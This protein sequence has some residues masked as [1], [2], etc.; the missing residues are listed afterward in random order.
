MGVLTSCSDCCG[1]FEVSASSSSRRVKCS[2]AEK[3]VKFQNIERICQRLTK[4]ELD[5][6]EEEDEEEK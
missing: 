3:K 4:L 6:E 1:M 5:E 2:L